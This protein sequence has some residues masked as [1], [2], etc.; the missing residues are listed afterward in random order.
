MP[1]LT[2]RLATTTAAW[3]QTAELRRSGKRRGRAR[4]AKPPARRASRTTTLWRR[5]RSQQHAPRLA[6][7]LQMCHALPA[8]WL[9]LTSVPLRRKRQHQRPLP[10]KLRVRVRAQQRARAWA[11]ARTAP[12]EPPRRLLRQR[13]CAP[14]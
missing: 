11:R 1:M 2:L 14:A 13:L 8:R 12:A 10:R 3:T 4:C 5:Y 9:L 6:A 7:Q